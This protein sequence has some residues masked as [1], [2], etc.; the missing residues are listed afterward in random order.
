MDEQNVKNEKKKE[1][2]NIYWFLLMVMA[3][4]SLVNLLAIS[5]DSMKAAAIVN[6]VLL[7][8]IPLTFILGYIDFRNFAP[9]NVKKE[10][11]YDATAVIALFI[12]LIHFNVRNYTFM[13][14]YTD[15]NTYIIWVQLRI[16]REFICERHKGAAH[17][18]KPVS[19]FH[20]RNIR[21][22]KVG[23]I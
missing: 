10:C 3:A 15:E 20:I 19:G 2:L 18:D 6:V 22:L 1:L 13:Q 9:M 8:A 23:D 11:A 17:L 16:F 14:D 12:S 21:H 5:T 7:F 4:V